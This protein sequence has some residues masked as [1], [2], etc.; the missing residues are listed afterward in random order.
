MKRSEMIQNIATDLIINNI[1]ID[2]KL[3][4]ELAE[5]MLKSAEK[6]GESTYWDKE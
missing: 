5:D 2:Y 1:N 4:Q 6:N 3:A